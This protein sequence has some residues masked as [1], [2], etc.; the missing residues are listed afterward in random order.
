MDPPQAKKKRSL[1]KGLRNLKQC[2]RSPFSS[3]SRS[4]QTVAAKPPTPASKAF[5]RRKCF[6]HLSVVQQ[7]FDVQPF[8]QT[9]RDPSL[10]QLLPRHRPKRWI[11]FN[12]VSTL[13]SVSCIIQVTKTFQKKIGLHRAMIPL[14]RMTLQ[15]PPAACKQ[16]SVRVRY[17][18]HGSRVR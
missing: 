9:F 17:H 3:K 4:S 16:E 6:N 15:F 10:T 11:V 13:R 7:G 1:G 5:G 18:H 12:S 8:P 14:T 2:L